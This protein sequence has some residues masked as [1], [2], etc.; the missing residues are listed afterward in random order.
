MRVDLLTRQYPAKSD[1]GAGAH[2]TELTKALR[3]LVDVRVRCF[4]SGAAGPDTYSYR[5]PGSPSESSALQFLNAGLGMADDCFSADVV[6][7]HTWYTNAAGHV[8]GRLYGIPHVMT[9]RS[10]A[11]DRADESEQAG[12]EH[13]LSDW[14]ERA[15]AGEADALIAG[16]AAL[17]EDILAAYPEVAPEKTQVI[18]SGIDTELWRPD[19]RTAELEQLGV[20]PERPFVLFLGRPTRRRGLVHL[21]RAAAEFRP[22]AQLVLCCEGPG[23]PETEREVAALLEELERLRSGVIRIDG[24]LAQPSL[25]QLI[26]QATAFVQPSLREPTGA[27]NLKAMACGTAVVATAVGAVPEIV[28]HGDTGLLVPYEQRADGSGDPVD[29]LR[30]AADLATSVNSLIDDPE[31][32]ERL[33]AAGRRRAATDFRWDDAAARTLAVYQRLTADS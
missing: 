29:P 33:G 20:D 3:R 4:D 11:T 27:V 7:S 21:L 32:A 14:M 1:G 24:A 12:G 2:T 19:P 5:E 16:S 25:R 30:L 28:A 8:A 18:H 22:Q 6:H 10:L 26:A 17:R 31:L 23:A 15:S 13:A 9:M